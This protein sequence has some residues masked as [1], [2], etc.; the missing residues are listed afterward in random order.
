LAAVAAALS[1]A[2]SAA[3]NL[4]RFL[5]K[6]ACLAA[7]YALAEFTT[8]SAANKFLSASVCWACKAIKS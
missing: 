3:F 5:S 1:A 4:T 7:A 8:A 6:I 2:A